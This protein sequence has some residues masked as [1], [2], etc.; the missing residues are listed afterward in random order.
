[1]SEAQ[2]YAKMKVAQL[3]ELLQNEGSQSKAKK[4]ELVE[5]LE[6]ATGSP[7]HP[8]TEGTDASATTFQGG[9]AEDDVSDAEADETEADE[10]MQAEK[11][12]SAVEADAGPQEPEPVTDGGAQPAATEA[13]QNEGEP[14]SGT[15]AEPQLPSG[16]EGEP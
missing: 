14:K 13:V 9:A 15:D 3:K 5:R 4:A 8:R 12:D 11:P 7:E 10:G 1:M 2:E 16:P 6:A